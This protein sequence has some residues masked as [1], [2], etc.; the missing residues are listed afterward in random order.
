MQKKKHNT[1]DLDFRNLH[2]DFRPT[3]TIKS[4]YCVQDQ[5][6]RSLSY[7]GTTW[8]LQSRL[9]TMKWEIPYLV[10]LLMRKNKTT[11]RKGYWFC[12]R[13]LVLQ[14]QNDTGLFSLNP[15]VL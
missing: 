13:L 12:K 9:S 6:R 15:F 5:P 7:V 3:R 2:W 1:Q 8:L 4:F 10:A 14:I 11:E